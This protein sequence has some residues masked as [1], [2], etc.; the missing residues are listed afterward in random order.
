M[1]KYNVLL[2]LTGQQVDYELRLITKNLRYRHDTYTPQNVAEIY[3]RRVDYPGFWPSWD[4]PTQYPMSMPVT[5]KW[6]ILPYCG[7]PGGS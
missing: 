5:L 3:L 2:R 1:T 6:G 4:Y 7:S